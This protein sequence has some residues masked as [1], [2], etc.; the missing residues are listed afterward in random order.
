MA[1]L[2]FVLWS[3]QGE[4]LRHGLFDRHP[5]SD[6]PLCHHFHCV[7][8]MENERRPCTCDVP[9]VLCICRDESS[10]GVPHHRLRAH[11]GICWCSVMTLQ[12]MFVPKQR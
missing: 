11:H 1:P 3:S 5:L 6:A 10:L 7:F 4:Q 9:P 2:C 8:Q 12:S